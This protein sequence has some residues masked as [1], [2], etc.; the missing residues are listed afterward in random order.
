MSLWKLLRYEST[1]RRSLAFWMLLALGISG[2]SRVRERVFAPEPSKL[3][4]PRW[5]E[6]LDSL[7][8]FRKAEF[9]AAIPL[10][11]P[12]LQDSLSLFRMGCP[13]RVISS[14]T[15][16]LAKGYSFRDSAQ[17]KRVVR[18]QKDWW[19]VASQRMRFD[20]SNR[21]SYRSRGSF[22]TA[23]DFDRSFR[24]SALSLFPFST[25]TLDPRDWVRLGL[26]EAQAEVAVRYVAGRAL[27]AGELGKLRILRPELLE[28]WKPHLRAGAEDVQQTETGPNSIDWNSV[29][30]AELAQALDWELERAQKLVDYRSRIGGFRSLEQLRSD[31]KLSAREF[32]KLSQSVQSEFGGLRLLDLNRS[33]LDELS[34]HP[35]IGYRNARSIVQFRESVRPFRSVEELQKLHLMEDSVWIKLAPYLV[36]R[37]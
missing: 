37:Y 17:L 29:G 19:A 1:E 32:D 4:S 26:S 7:S 30:A 24:T 28:S 3:E 18:P 12:N 20:D 16:F 31:R 34:A 8:A 36:V 14:W 5:T 11:D 22:D 27:N 15:S 6:L 21:K 33:A 9:E 13:D 25:D 35:Y 10:F 2:F 23:A